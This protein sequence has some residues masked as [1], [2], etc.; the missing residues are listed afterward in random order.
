MNSVFLNMMTRITFRI[1]GFLW[2]FC[3]GL[4]S[5]E[6]AVPL[7]QGVRGE[8]IVLAASTP[9]KE[10]QKGPAASSPNSQR[11]EMKKRGADLDN[12]VYEVFDPNAKDPLAELGKAEMSG[13]GHHHRLLW[14]V[15]GTAVLAGAGTAG[16]LWYTTLTAEA[17][18]INLDYNDGK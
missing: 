9:P 2:I 4:N 18:I 10:I 13:G 12:F 15:A 8:G 16:Y 7:P 5:L 11:E 17:K 6:A 14:F 1:T 3:L